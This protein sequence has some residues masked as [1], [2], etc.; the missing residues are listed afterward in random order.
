MGYVAA[1]VAV[2]VSDGTMLLE[3][4]G[5]ETAMAEIQ[6]GAAYA[7]AAGV[8]HNVVHAKDAPFALVEIERKHLIG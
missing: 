8:E 5:G 2:P 7:R 6:A 4:S 3:L 1:H